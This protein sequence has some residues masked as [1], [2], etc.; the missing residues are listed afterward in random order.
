[1]GGG[2]GGLVGFKHWI[3]RTSVYGYVFFP[4]K[5]DNVWLFRR[6]NENHEKKPRETP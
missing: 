2:V 3:P 5:D 1:M 4:S 6:N